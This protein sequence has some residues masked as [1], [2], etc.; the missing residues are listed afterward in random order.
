MFGV[1]NW[2]IAATVALATAVYWIFKACYMRLRFRGLVSAQ[3]LTLVFW[4]RQT[5]TH[6][7]SQASTAEALMDLGAHPHLGGGSW[8]VSTLTSAAD[9]NC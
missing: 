7:T 8:K 1:S 4:H 9:C 5:L 3:S 2:L 6:A